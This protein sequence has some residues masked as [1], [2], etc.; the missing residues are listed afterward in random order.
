MTI[1]HFEVVAQADGEA[2]DFRIRFNDG[3]PREYRVG[4]G[5]P[6]HYEAFF[7]QQA[8]DFGTRMPRHFKEVPPVGA[9][10]PWRPLITAILMQPLIRSAL[11]NWSKVREA[12]RQSCWPMTSNGKG[13]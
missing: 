9:E 10:P 6:L 7:E 5:D 8:R 4:G 13:I 2:T 11:A 12:L 3:E 1:P